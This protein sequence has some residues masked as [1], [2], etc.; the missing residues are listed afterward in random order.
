MASLRR[1]VHCHPASDWRRLYFTCFYSGSLMLQWTRQTASKIV[2]QSQKVVNGH[3]RAALHHE[4]AFVENGCIYGVCSY[5]QF[6]PQT[7]DV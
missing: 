1:H 6:V 4:H 7:G 5:G 2:W 3:G